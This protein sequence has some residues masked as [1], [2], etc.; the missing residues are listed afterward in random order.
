MVFRRPL[1]S[2]STAGDVGRIHAHAGILCA[3]AQGVVNQYQSEH[4]FGNRRGAQAD[5]R[6]VAAVGGQFDGIAFDVDGTARRGDTAG[7]LDGDVDGNILAGADAAQNAAGV[8][9]QEAFGGK[10]VA[11]FAAALGDAAETCTDFHAFDGVNRHHGIGDV[12]IQPVE[13]GFA[14]ADGYAA[15]FDGE[16]GTDGIQRFAYAVHIVFQFGNLALVGGEEGIVADVFV[17]F[18]GDGFFA[19]LGNVGGDVGA[20]RFFQPFFGNRA[21]GNAGCGFAGGAAAAAAVVAD[22][23][24]VPI[25]V[26]GVAGAEL[27]GD[28]AVVFAALVGIADKQGN[29][30]A[31]GSAFK[32][33]GKDFHFVGFAP[34]GNVAAGAGFAA[35]EVGL[36]V[37]GA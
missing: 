25:G 21:G 5:A 35:V 31:G 2:G 1:H 3:V 24:F 19:D 11:V 30:C 32:H 6:V 18:E 22:A 8:V 10:L 12:G 20:E 33:A 16:F 29:R 9:R 26:V 37:G 27:P 17:T 13:Y 28:V 15:G 23:V 36:D 34:L 14:Q 4:G 7:G